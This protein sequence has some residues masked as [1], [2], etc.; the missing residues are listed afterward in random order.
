ME[1]RFL[2]AASTFILISDSREWVWVGAIFSLSTTF[3]I[4]LVSWA[5]SV[6]YAKD[7]SRL[8]LLPVSRMTKTVRRIKNNPLIASTLFDLDNRRDLEF[9]IAKD[10]WAQEP[11]H[12]RLFLEKPRILVTD[13]YREFRDSE[14][15]RLEKTILKIGSL[16]VVGFG[17]AGTQI[18]GNN[19]Q[20][21]SS[22]GLTTLLPGRR[23]DAVFAFLSILDFAA[24]TEVL[25]GKIVVLVNQVAEIVHGIVDEFNGFTCKNTGSGFFLVWKLPVV[26][27]SLE[28]EAEKIE[29]E[30]ER[31]TELAITAFCEILCAI[32]RS[33]VLAVYRE[34]PHLKNKIPNFKVRVAIGLHLGW[35]I[36]GAA[37]SDFKLDASYLGLHASLAQRVASLATNV[38]RLPLLLTGPV[39]ETAGALFST[40]L[41]RRVDRVCFDASPSK[42]DLYTIDLDVNA[43]RVAQFAELTVEEYR[44][45]RD[46]ENR[47]EVSTGKRDS[48]ELVREARKSELLRYIYKKNKRTRK[49]FKLDLQAYQP[50]EVFESDDLLEMRAKFTSNHGNLF[51][52]LFD[53][54]VVNYLVGE[55]EVA[56][57]ALKQTLVFWKNHAT[58][59]ERERERDE[60]IVRSKIEYGTLVDAGDKFLHLIPRDDPGIDGPSLAL[61]EFMDRQDVWKGYRSF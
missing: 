3:F 18:I 46:L 9:E 25:E 29:H 27:K 39:A 32:N 57:N 2:I 31:L 1:I 10:R 47:V 15:N 23:V 19:I 20:D 21:S 50:L 37:G 8:I 13:Y 11:W 45:R 41:C 38:Y 48:L 55:W 4:F 56:T 43:V 54:G 26:E 14:T 16:L 44:R 53:K 61:L 30:R 7:C 33:P 34:H 59:E 17:E 36:E 58:R 51:K 5:A 28:P 49:R 6:A 42:L 52:Q 22:G 12:K 24:I 40:N 60:G 35:G